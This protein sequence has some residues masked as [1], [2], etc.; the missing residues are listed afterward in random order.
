MRIYL[1]KWLLAG[2]VV[3]ILLL[4]TGSMIAWNQE[5]LLIL[6]PSSI[7]LLSLGAGPNEFI[8]IAWAWSIGTVLNMVTYVF[9]GLCVHVA[10]F[11]KRAHHRE[12]S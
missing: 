11:L 10:L 7:V 1:L 4:T 8:D 5:L 9:I 2:L 6:W 12:H 3:P